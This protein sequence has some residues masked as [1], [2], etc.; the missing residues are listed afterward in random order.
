MRP[1]RNSLEGEDSRK[2]GWAKAVFIQRYVH[3]GVRFAQIHVQ[4]L[5]SGERR[6]CNRLVSGAPNYDGPPI[7]HSLWHLVSYLVDDS[8]FAHHRVDRA[9]ED[10]AVVVLSRIRS[11]DRSVT[12][13]ALFTPGSR[14]LR[15]TCRRKRRTGNVHRK[16][17][18]YN[19]FAMD[20][21]AT[22]IRRESFNPVE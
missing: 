4:S 6:L 10:W 20:E 3:G 11:R 18:R 16:S 14:K 15:P 21:T 19:F 9:S 22:R 13:S 8:W 5:V 1:E 2:A 17:L 12:R 7:L